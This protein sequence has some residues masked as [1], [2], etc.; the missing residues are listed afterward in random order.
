MIDQEGISQQIFVCFLL[1]G[2]KV[3]NKQRCSIVF[4][5]PARPRDAVKIIFIFSLLVNSL[6][7]FSV[8]QYSNLYDLTLLFPHALLEAIV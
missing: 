2:A 1:C 8:I 6:K 7:T 4:N 3:R 5:A